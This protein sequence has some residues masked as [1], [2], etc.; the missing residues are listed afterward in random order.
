MVE[1]IMNDENNTAPHGVSLVN[2]LVDD[3]RAAILK[4]IA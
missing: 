1:K 2:L 4:D 3:E